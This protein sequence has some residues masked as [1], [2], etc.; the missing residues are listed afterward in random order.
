MRT[1]LIGVL[2]ASAFPTMAAEPKDVIETAIK[3]HGGKAALSKYPASQYVCEGVIAAM[4][5]D[6]A[7][8]GTTAQADGGRLRTDMT[9]EV[10]EQKMSVTLATNGKKAS[11]KITYLGKDLPIPEGATDNLK[12]LA[13]LSDALKIYP[14]LDDERFALKAGADAEVDGKKASAI[15]VTLKEVS[16][17]VNGVQVPMK[18]TV[19]LDGAKYLT[20]TVFNYKLLDKVDD[21]TFNLDK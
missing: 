14:L 11:V 4:G 3:A 10:T 18:Q 1:M 9:I 21:A 5:Q 19:H 15:V 7:M 12:I 16:K 6:L 8:S 20:M 13:I 2:M 17:E